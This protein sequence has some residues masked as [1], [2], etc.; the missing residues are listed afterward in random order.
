MYF[1]VLETDKIP[2]EHD[3]KQQ[4]NYFNYFEMCKPKYYYPLNNKITN[5]SL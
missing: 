3:L 2:A 1:T 5:Y 4:V